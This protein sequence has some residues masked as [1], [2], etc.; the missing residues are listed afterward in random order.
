M[1][2]L[3]FEFRQLLVS[4]L[5]DLERTTLYVLIIRLPL[6]LFMTG[7]DCDGGCLR[8]GSLLCH[9]GSFLSGTTLLAGAA[10]AAVLLSK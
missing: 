9:I 2:K 6:Q 1:L 4:N 3:Y 7:F 10:T 5:L 8:G